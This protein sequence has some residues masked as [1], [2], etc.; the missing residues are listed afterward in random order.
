MLFCYLSKQFFQWN[1]QQ[2]GNKILLRPTESHCFTLN[3]FEEW[4][5]F[6]I[7]VFC[8]A[9]I[10]QTKNVSFHDIEHYLYKFYF[11]Q[12]VLC[13]I[14]NRDS[15]IQSLFEKILLQL[16]TNDLMYCRNFLSLI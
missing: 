1:V 16:P 11:Q 4:N 12:V 3:S 8:S 13:E 5:F 2:Q 6:K 15:M 10:L 7:I 9:R 14:L